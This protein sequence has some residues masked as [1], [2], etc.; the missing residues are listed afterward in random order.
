[1]EVIQ[2]NI[3]Q[4]SKIITKDAPIDSQ[5]ILNCFNDAYK[6]IS[7]PIFEPEEINDFRKFFVK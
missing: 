1:M 2:A 5:T 7:S 6:V 4:T 3:A